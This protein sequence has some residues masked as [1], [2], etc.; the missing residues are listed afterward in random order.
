MSIDGIRVVLRALAEV[1]DDEF[2]SLYVLASRGQPKPFPQIE[3]RIRQVAESADVRVVVHVEAG[4]PD[5]TRLGWALTVTTR[6]DLLIVEGCVEMLA[7]E[8]EQ[9]RE[10]FERSA[11]TSDPREADDLIRAFAA[12]IC[13]R[14]EWLVHA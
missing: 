7:P 6:G 3:F 2:Y 1:R 14:R 4:S 13:S 10:V 5:G 9:W 8:D 11:K 12:A